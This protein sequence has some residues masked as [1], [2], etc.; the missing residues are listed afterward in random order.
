MV[1]CLSETTNQKN[2]NWI[3]CASSSLGYFNYSGRPRFL[4][5]GLHVAVELK[6]AVIS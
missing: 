6:E 2:S 1:G 4:S 5:M 3:R